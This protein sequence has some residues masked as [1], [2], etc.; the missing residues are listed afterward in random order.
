MD[1]GMKID[2]AQGCNEAI[3]K[4]YPSQEKGDQ[5]RSRVSRKDVRPTRLS[6]LPLNIKPSPVLSS[7]PSHLTMATA[8][9]T[10][11]SAFSFT[12]PFSSSS[13]PK[14]RR[15]SLAT[16]ASERE[17]PVYKFRD[18]T[19]LPSPSE[20][21]RGKVRRL[22][23]PAPQEKKAR[24]KWTMEET[25]MLVE[26]CNRVSALLPFVIQPWGNA[27]SSSSPISPLTARRG[28]LESDIK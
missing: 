4:L 2:D 13:G 16:P 5:G 22:A 23:S 12:A 27:C 28:Q 20:E 25:Q 1:D 10:H 19:S 17:V 18:D 8:V 7:P 14:Q 21:R 6:T 9:T 11:T 15:V 26:G 24:K 3:E